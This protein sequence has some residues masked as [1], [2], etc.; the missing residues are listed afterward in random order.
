MALYSWVSSMRISLVQPVPCGN[1]YLWHRANRA[2]HMQATLTLSPFLT[3]KL[4]K[5]GSDLYGANGQQNT[6]RTTADFIERLRS[7]FACK[8][9]SFVSYEVPFGGL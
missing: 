1:S 8:I 7:I 3:Q 6:P 2:I 5:L 9:L 4:N